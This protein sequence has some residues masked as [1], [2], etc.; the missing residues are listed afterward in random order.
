MQNTSTLNV[1]LP[2]EGPGTLY[3]RFFER[4]EA[5]ERVA[6]ALKAAG[7]SFVAENDVLT[8]DAG[9]NDINDLVS[10]LGKTVYGGEQSAIKAIWEAQGQPFSLRECFDVESL[11]SFLARAQSD[12]FLELMR[13]KRFE[14][15]FQPIIS[16]DRPEQ[17]LAFEA[18]VR[19]RVND[20]LVAPDVLFDVARGLN[21]GRELDNAAWQCAIESAAKHRLRSKIFL[22][23]A[24]STLDDGRDMLRTMLKSIDEAG[25]LR[26]QIVFEIVE[27]E[28]IDDVPRLK[29]A[30]DGLKKS[31]FRIALDDLGAG[32]ASLQLLG[33]LRPD[34]VKL[35]RELVMGVD[36]DPF[37]ALIAQKLLE[38]ARALGVVTV[39]EGVESKAQWEWLKAHGGDFA[40]GYY[41]ARPSSP[42]PAMSSRGIFQLCHSAFVA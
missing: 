23:I 39:A 38:T 3:L 15:H 34:Y 42:P 16:V 28:C 9:N 41:F 11:R 40:Q 14:T 1:P 19:G 18:L 8:L 30:L 5:Q 32:Y 6:D 4:C 7:R 2:I 35:D 13:E 10:L 17:V 37:K 31:G 20:A 21:L 25:L 12:W 29:R 36:N 22:N 27:S 24:P 26:E 33:Q